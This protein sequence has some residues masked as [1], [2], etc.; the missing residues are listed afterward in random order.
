MTIDV[1]LSSN[2]RSGY[3][4]DVVDLFAK[5]GGARHQFRYDSRWISNEVL[6]RLMNGKPPPRAV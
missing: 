1:F 6:S 5:P 4:R 3:S 2:S